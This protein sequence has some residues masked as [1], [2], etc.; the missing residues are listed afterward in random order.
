MKKIVSNAL[1]VLFFGFALTLIVACVLLVIHVSRGEGQSYHD[2]EAVRLSG[3]TEDEIKY[4]NVKLTVCSDTLGG[5][6][7]MQN[8]YGY[9]ALENDKKKYL[10]DSLMESVYS[11]SEEADENGHYRISRIRVRGRRLSEF[12]I[13][14]VVNAFINDNPEYFWIENLF[15]YAYSDE[16][17]IVEFYSVLSAADCDQYIRRFNT[18]IRE[19]L[20]TVKDGLNEYQREKHI[21]DTLLGACSYKT[22]VTTTADGWQYFTSYGAM[23]EGEAV[24]EGYAKSMQLLLS[25]VGIP[26][27]M[28][29][30]DAEN[31]AHMWNVVEL[32]GE[33]Y[34]LDATWDDNDAEGNISYEYF[35]LTR[36]AIER[37]HSICDNIANIMEA[38]EVEDIDP[39]VRYN[40]YVPMCKEKAMN[41]YYVEGTLIQQLD[42]PTEELLTRIICERAGN[43]EAYIPLRFGTRMTFGTYV[44]KLFYEVPYMFYVC[45]ENA[46][47]QLDAQHKLDMSSLSILRNE[48]DMTLRVRLKYQ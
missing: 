4:E 15:G 46:N 18:R 35:N 5:F 34:Q 31:V 30:G 19:I 42:V 43:K 16:D 32:G 29:R 33:W 21:H 41:Y 38:A 10:Y 26:C 13:R 45:M 12:D 48:S 11:I 8:R 2:I 22:G 9:D 44:N 25:R 40:F 36:D 17:T 27:L 37:N 28:I 7:P 1:Y 14:E 47:A 20:S 6:M 39:L 3:S 23:V 24:C